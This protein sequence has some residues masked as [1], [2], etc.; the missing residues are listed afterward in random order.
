MNEIAISTNIP[1]MLGVME[2]AE[3]FGIAQRYAR[4]LALSGAVMLGRGTAQTAEIKPV[5]VKL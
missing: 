3:H 1:L 4:Q 2:T 5:P